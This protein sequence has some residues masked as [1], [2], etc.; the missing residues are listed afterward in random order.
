MHAIPQWLRASSE[1][2]FFA[3]PPRMIEYGVQVEESVV[4]DGVLELEKFALLFE[5]AVLWHFCKIL[6]WNVPDRSLGKVVGTTGC[7]M[8]KLGLL[9]ICD[10]LSK[11]HCVSG[12]VDDYTVLRPGAVEVALASA[13][14]VRL[15]L[16]AAV[17]VIRTG[18][19]DEKRPMA[20]RILAIVTEI[21][22]VAAAEGDDLVPTHRCGERTAVGR[23]RY[24]LG[25]RGDVGDDNI[26]IDRPLW[27]L[28][29]RWKTWLV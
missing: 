29:Q 27:L 5:L 3:V 13:L 7:E 8:F 20:F 18:R 1:S 15:I 22:D 21:F 28:M 9:L 14:E 10:R 11:I 16:G 4:G 24:A 19:F 26:E 12:L 25:V 6:A 17:S 23:L 2:E